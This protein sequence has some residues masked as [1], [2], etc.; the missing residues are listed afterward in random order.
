MTE[1]RILRIEISTPQAAM[2]AFAQTW[3]R[4]ERGE[5][6]TPVESIGFES[7]SEMLSTLT[8]RR[9]ELIQTVKRRGPTPIGELAEPVEQDKIPGCTDVGT[10]VDLGILEVDD[11]QRVFV[12]W[13]EIDLRVPLAA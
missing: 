11:R 3:E 6:V 13:D 10:L 12:P 4:L 9:W 7:L 2:E 8:P 5:A 1:R